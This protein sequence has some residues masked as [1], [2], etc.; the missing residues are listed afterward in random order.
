MRSIRLHAELLAAMLIG[1]AMP[2]AANAD[3]ETK[4]RVV[5]AN[6]I[7][8]DMVAQVAGPA[9]QVHCLVPSG[10]DIHGFDPKPGDVAQLAECDLVV[11]NGAGF[12]PWLG[13]LIEAAGFSGPHLEA[14]RGVPLLQRAEDDAASPGEHKHAHGRGA[15]P[16]S[17]TTV[18]PHAWQNPVNGIRYVL[19]IRDVLVQIVPDARTGIERRA[20]LY[21]SQLEVLHAWMHR[22]FATISPDDRVI[23]TSHDSFAYLAQVAGLEIIPVR[24][25]DS[26]QEPDARRI[27]TLV[28]ELRTRNVRAIFVEA[29]SNPKMLQQLARDTGATIGGEL[30]SDSLGP[31]GSGADSY[32]G[33]LRENALA[34]AGALER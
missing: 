11:S 28:D 24:G 12:E 6:T 16:G 27:A 4:P 32:L 25:L 30:F 29:V 15:S 26:R 3:A 34:V 7:L 31:A 23:V 9:V 20:Q 17:A 5:A 8:A 33:M 18:D 22:I 2:W 1:A 14:S 13:K 10:V 21:V 19:N